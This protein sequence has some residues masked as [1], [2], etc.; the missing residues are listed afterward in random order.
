VPARQCAGCCIEA[1]SLRAAETIDELERAW[2]AEVWRYSHGHI[3]ILL[4][5]RISSA[6]CAVDRSASDELIALAVAA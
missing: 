1:R 3:S 6:G 4:S 2:R 5:S